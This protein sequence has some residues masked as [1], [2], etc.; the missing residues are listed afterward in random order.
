M[1]RPQDEPEDG[2]ETPWPQERDLTLKV[3]LP[4]ALIPLG[5]TVS[6]RTG[7]AQYTLGDRL[8]LFSPNEAKKE[9][10]A[11]EGTRFLIGTGDANAIPDSTELVWEINEED[12][13]YFLE[14]RQEGTPQ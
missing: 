2:S 10:V 11:Q 12:L 9:I 6:K 8:R 14:R 1:T 7:R 4:A 3:I 13:L 5:S